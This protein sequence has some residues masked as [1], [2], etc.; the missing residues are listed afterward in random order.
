MK[1]YASMQF[2]L[3]VSGET[4]ITLYE[5]SGRIIA[6]TRDFLS[7]GKH[8]YGYKVLKKVYILS[9]STPVIFL[10]WQVD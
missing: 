10:Y 5:I 1:D 7:T 4:L 2:I 9:G 8:T 6:Q 3:P